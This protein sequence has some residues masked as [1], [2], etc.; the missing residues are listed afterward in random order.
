MSKRFSEK[1][2]TFE[3]WLA[4][5]PETTY[6]SRIR[7]LHTLYPEATLSQLRGHVRGREVTLERKR[8]KAP[9]RRRF[10]ELSPREKFLRERSLRVISSMRRDGLSLS[11]A[12]GKE[13]ISPKT[14]IRHTGVLTKKGERYRATK[15]DRIERKMEINERGRSR[16]L[17]VKDSRRASLIGKY[18]NAVRRSLE[19]GDSS[20]LKPFIGKRVRDSDG[21]WHV[22]ETDLDALYEIQERGEDEEFRSIY[23]E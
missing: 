3:N 18:Q 1:Y 12:S 19:T 21:N 9:H 8:P 5:A 16:H 11:E 7:R 4:Q 22:L 2:A 6:T 13:G 15:H 10:D 14:V 20:F 17:V 23:A